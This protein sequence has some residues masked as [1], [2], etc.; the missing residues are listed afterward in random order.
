MPLILLAAKGNHV[1]ST[2]EGIVRTRGTITK[3]NPN[4]MRVFL[5]LVNNHQCPL[6]IGSMQRIGS[7]QN[8]SGRIEHITRGREDLMR[9]VTR[10]HPFLCN[11]LAGEILRCVLLNLIVGIGS[12]HPKGSNRAATALMDSHRRIMKVVQSIAAR[13]EERSRKIR[14]PQ[15]SERIDER[16]ARIPRNIKL[17]DVH[18]YVRRYTIITTYLYDVVLSLRFFS[19]FDSGNSAVYIQ[20]MLNRHVY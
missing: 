10:L 15:G 11:Q 20:L 2:G 4:R 16:F 1:Y 17:T 8:V 9:S 12:K 7:H 18:W 6:A 14:Q 19:Y 13:S 5:I 3:I